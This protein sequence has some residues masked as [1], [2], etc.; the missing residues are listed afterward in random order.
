AADSVSAARP[1]ARRE[2]LE[3]Y[4]KRLERLESIALEFNG[5]E[6]VF[7]LQAGREVR[8][9]VDPGNVSDLDARELSRRIARKLEEDLQ[10]PGQIQVTVIREFRATDY[11]R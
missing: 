6:Q 2:T 5:V 3:G 10:Y 8:V 11:A 9:V 4:I 1:G 7:A